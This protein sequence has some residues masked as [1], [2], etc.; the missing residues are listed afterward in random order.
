MKSTKIKTI[1]LNTLIRFNIINQ[2]KLEMRPLGKLPVTAN[3]ANDNEFIL[4]ANIFL[5]TLVLKCLL[6]C[7]LSSLI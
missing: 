4:I 6:H 7:Q 3:F 5:I 2:D 1:S